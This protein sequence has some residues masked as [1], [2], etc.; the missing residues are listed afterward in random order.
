MAA[1]PPT[2]TIP[3]ATTHVVRRRLVALL[4]TLC[5]AFG[6]VVVRLVLVQAVAAGPYTRLGLA[7]RTADLELPARRGAILDRNGRDL[8][9][10]V[11]QRTVWAD[12]HEVTD[13]LDA[14]RQLAP[15]LGVDG[16]TLAERM[17]RN[18]SFVYL[19][20]KVSDDVATRVA[21][22]NIAG[23]A[24][25]DEPKR[26]VP[27]GP[28]AAPVLGT[29]GL[30]NTGLSGL[31]LQ[32][33]RRLRGTPGT[34]VVERDPSGGDILGGQRRFRPP[35]AGDDLVLTL[36]RSLQ[37]EA[38]RALATA[39]SRTNSKGGLAVVMDPRSGD[40][41]A[42]ANL[43]V[44]PE[45]GAVGP[46]PSNTAVTSVYEPGSVNKLITLGAALEERVVR[47]Y[48]VLVVPDKLR[49]ADHVFSDAEPHPTKPMTVTEI[50]AESSNI[51]TIKIAQRLGKARIDR[52]LRAFG[53]GSKTPLRFPGEPRGLLLDPDDWSGTSIG[54][55]PIGQGIAVTAL[56]MLDAY[57]TV[58]NGGVLA[59]PRLVQRTIG[60]DGSSSPVSPPP[61]ARVVSAK[62]AA[63]LTAMLEEVVRDGTGTAAAIRGYTVA[64]KTGTARK[65]RAGAR[66]YAE[67]AFIATF[68]GFVP[69][70][71]P[72]LSAIVVL[73]QPTP[74]YG[75]I[76]AA[77]VFAEIAQYALR[78]LRIPPSD[79]A[80]TPSPASPTNTRA[81]SIPA[82][83]TT[84]ASTV[85]SR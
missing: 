48:D 74:I 13:P 27:G 44:D 19:A 32:Y 66:G 18:A 57:N 43:T 72:R 24:L 23:V 40:I 4:V 3:S 46:A 62:T 30:D 49:V 56:Q 70:G 60:P 34:R 2:T 63:Q 9:L 21:A 71:N 51:G 68:A 7:Q 69:A 20:R 15:V 45:T 75:G 65:P 78:V 64:G 41:L 36:D 26:F 37:F 85:P 80:P 82:P 12:P 52:Y 79:G 38:E 16:D 77:P 6:A 1:P 59:P 17:S 35:V 8:A 28:L 73:D 14:A 84:T 54:S 47:P 22:M 25:L 39:V 81:T 83:S 10:S 29:V 61:A 31:E 53:F 50:L 33:N 67:G 58:A 5:V 42:M 55:I 11:A 76:V